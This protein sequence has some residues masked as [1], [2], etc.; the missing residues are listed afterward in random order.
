MINELVDVDTNEIANE[1]TKILKKN[2]RRSN[3]D[4]DNY[5][6]RCN[7]DEIDI[8]RIRDRKR[9]DKEYASRSSLASCSYGSLNVND[10]ASNALHIVPSP[11]FSTQGSL[12]SSPTTEDT[13]FPKNLVKNFSKGLLPL[14]NLILRGG[15]ENAHFHSSS[16]SR[17]QTSINAHEEMVDTESSGYRN[18]N[19][20]PKPKLPREIEYNN[21]RDRGHHNRKTILTA[22]LYTCCIFLL[23]YT[24]ILMGIFYEIYSTHQLKKEN[25]SEDNIFH[26]GYNKNGWPFPDGKN[27][28][29]L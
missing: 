29:I 13:S 28:I 6:D 3:C 26:N 21:P 16:S 20:H 22:G 15:G 27:S 8:K 12:E 17:L 4:F 5:S 2:D 23:P 19:L 1:T 14:H 18:V 25:V 10:N 11:S 24:L 9:I 7:A